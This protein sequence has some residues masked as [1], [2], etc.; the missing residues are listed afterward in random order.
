MQNNGNNSQRKNHGAYEEN[1]LLSSKQY[2]FIQGGSTV[3]Q[4]SKVLDVWTEILDRRN[5]ID[6]IYMDFKKAFDTVPHKRL[7]AEIKSYGIAGSVNRWMKSFVN[8]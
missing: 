5:D 3:L 8:G 1:K 6:I 7:L 2:G 4:L